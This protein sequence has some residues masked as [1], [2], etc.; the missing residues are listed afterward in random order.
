MIDKIGEGQSG[1]VY[2]CK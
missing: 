1:L 2:K